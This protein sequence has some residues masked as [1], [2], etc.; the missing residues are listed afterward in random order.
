MLF[1]RF[2]RIIITVVVGIMVA[3]YLG[4]TNLGT[5]SYALSLATL[6]SPLVALGLNSILARELVDKAEEAEYYIGASL[7]AKFL[8]FGLS[9]P[10]LGVFCFVIE[11]KFVPHLIIMWFSLL[12]QALTSFEI[13]NQATLQGR[14]TATVMLI[15]TLVVS[16]FKLLLIRQGASLIYFSLAYTLEFALNGL[17]YLIYFY[18]IDKK[19]LKFNDAKKRILPMLAESWPLIFSGFVI[20]VYM[21]IDQIMIESILGTRELGNYSAAV[22]LSEG[23][24]FL[25]MILANALFPAIVKAKAKDLPTYRMAM[26]KL[27]SLMTF[28][29]FGIAIFMSVLSEPIAYLLFK[30][31]FQG[32]G[33][34]LA[35]HVWSGIFVFWGTM[36]GKY[37][38]LEKIQRYD[39]VGTIIGSVV[40]IALNFVLLPA[41]G[42]NGAAIAT[43]IA[44]FFAGFFC[45]SWFAPTR[46]FFFYILQSFNP[47]YLLTLIRDV[48]KR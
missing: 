27:L 28:L 43:V 6:A 36:A 12:F 29:S 37:L 40:N 42:I 41:Y 30:D 5:Y 25:P 35:L 46:R 47:R 24:Y 2:A 8:S 44:Y 26:L 13:Y 22:R 7:W 15:S 34:V 32:V 38:T 48:T 19:Y 4:A 33:E 16:V 11:A 21:K 1:E 23:Y 10:I 3:N 20:I 31:K 14:R 39:L 17:L 9:L 45:Y 18:R